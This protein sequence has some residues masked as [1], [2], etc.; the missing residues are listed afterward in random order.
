MNASRLSEILLES[1]GTVVRADDYK[2]QKKSG[3]TGPRHNVIT[4]SREAGAKG[5]T[6][7][8]AVGKL[9]GWPVYDHELLDRVG[10][11][12]GTHVDLVKL[13]DE[14][15]M[16]WLEQCVVSLVSEYNLSHDSYMVHL[17]ATVRALG[18]EGNCVIVGRGANLI[19][20]HNQTLNVRLVGNLKNR[21][22]HIQDKLKLS[23]KEA[24]RWV[25][26][27]NKQRHDF[28]HNHFGKDV[29]DLSNYDL[30]LNTS[31]LGV[32][33]CADTI[34]TTLHRLQTYRSVTLH[35]PAVV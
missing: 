18:E 23:D 8:R 24:A 26:K 33:E 16:S 9:L 1:L 25:E 31:R 27:T 35:Q 32:A 34:V 4:I 12:M 30:G 6:I 17:I 11:E 15:P 21:I 10:K 19:L 28:V 20:P 3:D 29:A 5:T 2:E 14:K 13:V 7:A 22:A